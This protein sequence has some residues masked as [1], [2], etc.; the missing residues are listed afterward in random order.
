MILEPLVQLRDLI[1][2]SRCCQSG[3]V[4]G[5]HLIQLRLLKDGFG[6]WSL[7]VRVSRNA[8]HFEAR[9]SQGGNPA[10]SDWAIGRLCR[11]VHSVFRQARHDLPLVPVQGLR[12][13]QKF[14]RK[15]IRIAISRTPV[16][17][18]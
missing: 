15:N 13:Q 7:G 8:S 11:A 6:D 1:L 17:H 18:S 3:P 16:A 5:T 2:R 10:V 14:Q 12:S 9:P 4:G